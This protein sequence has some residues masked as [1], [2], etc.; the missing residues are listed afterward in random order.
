MRNN[1]SSLLK[2]GDKRLFELWGGFLL[3]TVHVL[4]RTTS[5]RSKKTPYELFFN[6]KPSV[7]HLRV[8]GCRAY[9]H[10]P[11]E[12]RKK[13]DSKAQP[14]WLVGYGEDTKGWIVLEPIS[15]KFIMSRDVILNEDLLI[16]DFYG[17]MSQNENGL[18]DPFLLS[19]ETLGLVK[20]N[21]IFF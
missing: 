3:S 10:V 21:N 11:D 9:I 4:N 16:S 17:G 6:K 12:L 19:L 1:Q 20:R 18:F 14:G 15:R 8:M 7:E 5:S 13:L 2:K